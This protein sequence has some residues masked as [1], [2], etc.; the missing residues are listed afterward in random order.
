ME[1]P[2]RNPLF[3][4]TPTPILVFF[5]DPLHQTLPFGLYP[6]VFAMGF[7]LASHESSTCSKG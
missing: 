5:V 4:E 7:L 3:S 6:M 2:I 1:I